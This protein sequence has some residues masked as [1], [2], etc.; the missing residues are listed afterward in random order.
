MC[1]YFTGNL[2]FSGGF[3]SLC[4]AMEAGFTEALNAI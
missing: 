1:L 4:F 2:D 3:K